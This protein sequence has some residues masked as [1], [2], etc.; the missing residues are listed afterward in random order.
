MQKQNKPW[1]KRKIKKAAASTVAVGVEVGGFY[2]R[3][4]FGLSDEYV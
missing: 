1:E 2:P 3:V 4:P